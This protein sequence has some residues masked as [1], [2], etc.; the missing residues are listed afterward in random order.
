MKTGIV[1]VVKFLIGLFLVPVVA[2]V[3]FS[4]REELS[5]IGSAY[6]F[7]VWGILA[8]VIFHLFIFV[9]QT[10]YQSGQRVFADIFGFFPR[11]ASVMPIVVPL[12]PV[13]TLF[14]L[15]ICASSLKVPGVERY[16]MF[17]AGFVLAVHVVLTARDLY[18]EDMARLKGRYLLTMCLVYIT[19]ILIVAFLIDL[20]FSEFSFLKFF[21]A[22]AENIGNAYSGLFFGLI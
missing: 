13:M 4:F 7:F 19:N 5:G 15:Y 12:L 16:F 14:L 21:W 10:L 18:E 6:D 8:Y 22:G 11:L 1:S 17:F 20:N 3:T 2:A 9:P